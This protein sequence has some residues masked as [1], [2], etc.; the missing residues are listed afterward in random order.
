M[1]LEIEDQLFLE[2]KIWNLQP[3]I[4]KDYEIRVCVYDTKNMINMD[5]EGTSDVYITSYIDEKEK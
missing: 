1:W 2:N 5:L 4:E 3:E